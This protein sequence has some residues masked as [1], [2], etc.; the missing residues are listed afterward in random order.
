MRIPLLANL[1]KDQA[2]LVALAFDHEVERGGLFFQ[3]VRVASPVPLRVTSDLLT[4]RVYVPK[5]REITAFGGDLE[6]VE[7]A[8]I[9]GVPPARRRDRAVPKRDPRDGRSISPA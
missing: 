5:E 6:R 2:F 7:R 8:P 4:W 3:S 9:V 1:G